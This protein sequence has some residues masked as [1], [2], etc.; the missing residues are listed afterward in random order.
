VPG[1]LIASFNQFQFMKP[2]FNSK[3]L[4]R[5]NI[6]IKT[7]SCTVF[8]ALFIKCFLAGLKNEQIS[9]SFLK[10]K[11]EVITL[12]AR[13]AFMHNSGLN[14]Y[15][16]VLKMLRL[17]YLSKA[18]KVSVSNANLKPGCYLHNFQIRYNMKT[19]KFE[20]HTIAH[21]VCNEWIYTFDPNKGLY[22][23]QRK[24]WAEWMLCF[25]LRS[26]RMA[27]NSHFCCIGNI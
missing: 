19:Q 5:I 27:T 26:Y 22:K 17:K 14:G 21:I 25:C 2:L 10:Y 12:Q 13:G 16:Y 23:I 9:Q 18:I 6:V 3:N 7:G 1:N 11:K 8:S 4:L 20:T 24:K 15:G